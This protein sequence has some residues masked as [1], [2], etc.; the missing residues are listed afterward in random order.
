MRDRLEII[1]LYTTT[2]H[3]PSNGQAE[4]FNR[5]LLTS[6]RAYVSEHPRFWTEYL[7]AIAYA[8]ITQ[9]HTS[10]GQSPFDL[11]LYNPPLAML[12]QNQVE[13]GVPLSAAEYSDHFLLQ[14]HRLKLFA[15]RRLKEAQHR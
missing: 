5:T 4:C 8:Y 9:V 14:L 13:T 7:G 11:V 6:F 15:Q 3:L 2:Y 10:T 12:M 1:N